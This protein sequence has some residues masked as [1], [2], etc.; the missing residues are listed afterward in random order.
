[1]ERPFE[2][3]N[4]ERGLRKLHFWKHTSGRTTLKEGFGN[5]TSGK[6]LREEQL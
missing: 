1:L 2:K 6:A 3:N 4:S 5:C